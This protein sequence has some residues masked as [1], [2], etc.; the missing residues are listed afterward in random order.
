MFFFISCNIGN[1]FLSFPHL[2]IHPI[3]GF[4]HFLKINIIRSLRS[5]TKCFFVPYGLRGS[6][7]KNFLVTK[8]NFSCHSPR[9]CVKSH[10]YVVRLGLIFSTLEKI[11]HGRHPILNNLLKRSFPWIAHGSNDQR[12]QINLCL[13]QVASICPLLQLNSMNL[14]FRNTSSP[15]LL[16][17][18]TIREMASWQQDSSSVAIL[19]WLVLLLNLVEIVLPLCQSTL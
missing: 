3:H 2:I 13:Y 8:S 15:S 4:W 16:K 10:Q 1:S 19:L 18:K 11:N 9:I 14:D 6:V 5:V 7:E 17:L 12:L